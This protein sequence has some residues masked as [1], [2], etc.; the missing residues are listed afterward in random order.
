MKEFARTG[1]LGGIRAGMTGA[2][3]DAVAGPP[4]GW[5]HDAVNAAAASAQV[6]GGIWQYGTIELFWTN[7]RLEM[8]YWDDPY[9]CPDGGSLD[10]DPWIVKPGASVASVASAFESERIQFRT[11]FNPKLDHIHLFTACG[12]DFAFAREDEEAAEQPH[13]LF[14]VSGPKPPHP[15]IVFR[16]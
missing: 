7:S 5:N 6:S 4:S 3:V 16:E 13:V 10:L 2:E 11:G 14:S 15:H 8:F 12:A 1:V 9:G